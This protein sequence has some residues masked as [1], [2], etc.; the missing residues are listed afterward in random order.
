MKIKKIL[1]T[2]IAI[3]SLPLTQLAQKPIICTEKE[4]VIK[5]SPDPR[6]IKSCTF[7]NFKSVSKGDPDYKG[8]YSYSYKIF[9]LTNNKYVAI[10]NSE[11]FNENK[12]K[13]LAIINQK[14][15]ETYL[16][17]SN[18]PE[19][20]DCF[21]GISLPEVSFDDLGISFNDTGIDFSITFG[22][23]GSCMAVDGTTL[24]F[25]VD[26]IKTYINK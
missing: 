23:D 6:I 14:I 16:E 10:K 22:L 9:K 1:I 3:L 13:L 2:A 11:L 5:D 20:K 24:S 4:Q 7:E 8:R 26:E 19:T 21:D 15:K 12:K 18:N 17:Y 25:K